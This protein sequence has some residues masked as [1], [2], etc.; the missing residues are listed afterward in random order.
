M[1]TSF[2][3]NKN[4]QLKKKN[5]LINKIAQYNLSALIEM[6]ELICRETTG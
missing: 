6:T 2:N 5:I 1:K 3:A 4:K